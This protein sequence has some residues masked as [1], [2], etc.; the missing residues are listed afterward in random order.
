MSVIEQ[1][2]AH[3]TIPGVLGLVQFGVGTKIRGTSITKLLDVKSHTYYKYE[4]L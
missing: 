1:V 4:R 3:S 2:Y